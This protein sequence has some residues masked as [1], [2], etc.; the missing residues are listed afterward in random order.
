[1]G[2][3]SHPSND[4]DSSDHLRDVFRIEFSNT[5]HPVYLGICPSVSQQLQISCLKGMVKAPVTPSPI[6]K[7]SHCPF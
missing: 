1:M 6:L 3:I 2:K 7:K 5:D 4:L